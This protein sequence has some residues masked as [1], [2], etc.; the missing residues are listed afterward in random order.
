M[1]QKGKALFNTGQSQ[2]V[3][4]QHSDEMMQNADSHNTIKTLFIS[5]MRDKL[6][7]VKVFR[8]IPE[9][10]ILRLTFHRKSAS[11]SEIGRF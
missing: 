8:I 1:L 4:Q 10:N 5:K 6:S 11:T 9:F 7:W 2:T 3:N